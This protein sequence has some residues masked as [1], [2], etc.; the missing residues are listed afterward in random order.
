[1]PKPVALPQDAESSEDEF[2]DDDDDEGWLS[3]L[4]CFIFLYF[5]AHSFLGRV[6]LNLTRRRR[7]YR[8][9]RWM[10]GKIS[11]EFKNVDQKSHF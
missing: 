1:M 6:L 7:L 2:I 5:V 8:P 4:S 11:L 10:T 3:F 9:F